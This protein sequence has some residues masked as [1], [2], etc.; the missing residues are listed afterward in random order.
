MQLNYAPQGS[1]VYFEIPEAS[2]ILSYKIVLT[3]EFCKSSLLTVK[4]VIGL[5]ATKTFFLKEHLLSSLGGEK[6]WETSTRIQRP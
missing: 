1:I 2:V 4:M 3:Q 5:Y 6:R